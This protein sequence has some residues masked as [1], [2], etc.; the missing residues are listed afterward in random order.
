VENPEVTISAQC[1]FLLV[2]VSNPPILYCVT[3]LPEVI[4][5]DVHWV[6]LDPLDSEMQAVI[7][8]FHIEKVTG[9][10]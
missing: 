10:K 7:P 2:Y 3:S 8:S 9:S 4:Y 6:D 5:C 1:T